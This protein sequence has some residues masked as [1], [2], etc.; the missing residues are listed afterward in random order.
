MN[1]YFMLTASMIIL[2]Q[3]LTY[4]KLSISKNK[5]LVFNFEYRIPNKSITL[6]ILIFLV[7]LI[8]CLIKF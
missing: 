3:L 2:N 7:Y 1:S 6:I 5:L 4:Y 8:E